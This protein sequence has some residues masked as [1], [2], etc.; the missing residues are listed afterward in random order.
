MRLLR[1]NNARSPFHARFW[2][3]IVFI[4]LLGS[5]VR[6]IG[7]NFGLPY[8]DTRDEAWYFTSVLTLR[9]MY[10]EPFPLRG[11][12]PGIF[13]IYDIAQR[14][15]EEVTHYPASD[16]PANTINLVRLFAIVASILTI[17]IVGLM[18]RRLQ[19][20]LAGIIA[21][22]AWAVIPMVVYQSS[23]AYPDAWLLLFS[24][25]GLYWALLGLQSDWPGWLVLS[26]LAGL[27]AI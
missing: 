24:A 17:P 14:L 23:I 12:P 10:N 8:I 3:A 22:A 4:V 1:E 26:T 2:G 6:L 25:L 5:A 20:E 21:A 7:Y 15:V 11:Y 27:G 19:G 16:H 18:A 13:A 9:G